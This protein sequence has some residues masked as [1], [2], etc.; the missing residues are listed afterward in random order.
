M[1][2]IYGVLVWICHVLKLQYIPKNEINL[3]TF[4]RFV[5][6]DIN[7]QEHLYNY[8][9]EFPPIVKNIEYSNNICGEYT[10]TLLYNKFTKSRK[11]IATL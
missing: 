4:F 1:H 10:T 5:E 7:V 11:L 2:Y 3:N 6:V 8:F 9:S